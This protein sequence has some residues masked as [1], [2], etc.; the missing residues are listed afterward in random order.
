MIMS[1]CCF[2]KGV[3]CDKNERKCDKCGWNPDVKKKRVED[4]K[5]EQKLVELD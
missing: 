5:K 2:N 4:W 1:C 3:E